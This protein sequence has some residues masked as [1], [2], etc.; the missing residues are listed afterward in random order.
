M[1]APSSIFLLDN[2]K[3]IEIVKSKS[4]KK[5]IS[6]I[7]NT[8]NVAVTNY[9]DLSFADKS[10]FTVYYLGYLSKLNQTEFDEI[11]DDAMVF[12]DEIIWARSEKR[13]IE[14]VSNL[15]FIRSYVDNTPAQLVADYISDHINQD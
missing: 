2:A 14:S 1:S 15:S 7:L 5:I 11:A 9:Y 8:S 12:V 4:E 10:E 6:E 13:F 3:F